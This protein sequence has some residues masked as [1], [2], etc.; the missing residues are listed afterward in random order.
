M[1]TDG[2]DIPRRSEVITE[3]RATGGR[4][5]AVLPLHYPRALF[6]A[7][8]ILPVEVWGPPGINTETGD[9]HL[10]AYTCSIVRAAL[11]FQLEGGL[12]RTDLLLVPHGCDSLQGLG[13]VLR[14]FLDPGKPVLTLYPPRGEG[15]DAVQYLADELGAK[16]RRLQELTGLE[17]TDDELLET[18]E[19]EEMADHA[20]AELHA[21]RPHLP[22]ADP[23][24]YR[25]LRAREY[26]PAEDFLELSEGV[27]QR[28][29]K[30]SQDGVP[31]LVSGVLPEPPEL[32]EAI[33]DAGGWIA[34]DDFI[35]TGRRVYPAGD[36]PKPLRR[37]AQSLLGAPPDSTRGSSVE[38]RIDHLIG[39]ARQRS[40][41]A[42]VFYIVKFCEPEQF[43]QPLLRKAL[44]R[45]GIR[46]VE[47]E[48]DI[49][50]PY[51]HQATTR[52]EALLET[53]A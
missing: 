45:H 19:L 51:P 39:M 29:T 30:G 38:A 52:L 48:V 50:D 26:L 6:R 14:D 18:I 25:V 36:S 33:T 5:A 32:L 21:G 49:S 10:Q 34:V 43:Y 41:Q 47:I 27:L 8:D 24:M 44:E 37:M 31:L 2:I 42:A 20:L 17:P 28:R 4:V 11:A 46:C 13:S 1:G 40:V 12:D 7:F 53:V 22:L 15:P 23:E 3:H 9:E 35:C 16:R